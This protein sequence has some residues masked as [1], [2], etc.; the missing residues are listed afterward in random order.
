MSKPPNTQR[1]PCVRWEASWDW[2]DI[3]SWTMP[4]PSTITPMAL[5]QEKMKSLRLLTMVRGSVS[6]AR[7]GQVRAAH[8]VSMRT[9]EK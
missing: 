6:A 3:P 9:A 4:Q 8:R 5:M 2:M 7:A 1:M